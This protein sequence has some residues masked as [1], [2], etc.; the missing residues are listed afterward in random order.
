MN[1]EEGV[2]WRVRNREQWQEQREKHLPAG[3]ALERDAEWRAVGGGK[4]EVR[5]V[6]TW[7]FLQSS[8]DSA[9][10]EWLTFE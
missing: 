2:T 5:T 8:E 3:R 10:V 7:G 1:L 4:W 9:K 6:V